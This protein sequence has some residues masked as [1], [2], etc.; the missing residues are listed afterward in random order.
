MRDDREDKR[1]KQASLCF[2]LRAQHVRPEPFAY[3]LTP[4]T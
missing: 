1:K 3:L 2:R 4:K